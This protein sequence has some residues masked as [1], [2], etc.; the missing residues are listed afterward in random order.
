MIKH[1][2]K[3]GREWRTKMEACWGCGTLQLIA[4][5]K[6]AE[7]KRENY[8]WQELHYQKWVVVLHKSNGCSLNYMHVVVCPETCMQWNALSSLV[9][10]PQNHLLGLSGT[11]M[12][13][14]LT[15]GCPHKAG[16]C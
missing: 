11:L 1:A 12:D 9:N 6:E 5:A 3:D 13:T 8:R 15:V 14:L 2:S 4:H 10:N 7:K 16:V